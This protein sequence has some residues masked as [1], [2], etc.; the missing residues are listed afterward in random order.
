MAEEFRTEEEQVEALKRWWQENGK[1][2]IAVIVLALAGSLGW[3]SWQQRMQDQAE[4]ASTVYQ[5]MLD[6]IQVSGAAAAS[7][8]QE[9]TVRHLA[10][11]LKAD[12]SGSTYAQFAALHLAKLAVNAEDLATAEAELRW[13]LNSG[14]EADLQRVA[15]LRLARV[16]AAAGNP[17][18]ALTMLRGENAGAYAAAY[19][20]AEGDIQQQLGNADAALEAYQRAAELHLDSG[21][22]A[23]TLELKLQAL[24]QAQTATAEFAAS[25]D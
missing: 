15:Q 10:G 4:A 24:G 3:Q 19:A 12:F 21:Q 17:E 13:V 16:V 18:S 5:S 2:T 7:P 1:S 6:A 8:D 20:E 9:A 11:T 23:P 14:P 22:S 25:E